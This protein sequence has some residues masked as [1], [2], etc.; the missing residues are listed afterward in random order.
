MNESNGYKG[1]IEGRPQQE[2]RKKILTYF[3]LFLLLSFCLLS[4]LSLPIYESQ[5]EQVFLK[6]QKHVLSLQCTLFQKF[7]FGTKNPNVSILWQNILG[8]KKS[9]FGRELDFFSRVCNELLL[10]LVIYNRIKKRLK[11]VKESRVQLESSFLS[12]MISPKGTKDRNEDT[13]GNRHRKPKK[14][15][16]SIMNVPTA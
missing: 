14:K 7:I 3:Y 11:F 9:T 16:L 15:D 1:T 6:T 10:S 8:R 13:K 2:R 5:H 12:F 4:G